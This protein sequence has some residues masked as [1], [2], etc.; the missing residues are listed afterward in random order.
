MELAADHHAVPS[1]GLSES[2]SLSSL[3]CAC[4]LSLVIA[5]GDTGKLLSAVASLLMSPSSLATQQLHVPTIL[6]RLQQSAQAVLLGRTQL[7]EWLSEG[8]KASALAL[9]VPI[10]H[11]TDGSGGGSSSR[12]LA[13]DGRFLYIHTADGLLKVGTGYGATIQVGSIC[14][15]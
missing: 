7:P 2:E 1:G 13:C 8:V 3:A 5:R 12:G 4:L 11:L 10:G 15:F 14:I 9:T 6:V